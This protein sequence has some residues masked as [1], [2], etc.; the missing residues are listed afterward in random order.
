[1]DVNLITNSLKTSHIDYIVL[2]RKLL[3]FVE[4]N[5]DINDSSKL[6]QGRIVEQMKGYDYG[7]EVELIFEVDNGMRIRNPMSGNELASSFV[8]MKP[9]FQYKQSKDDQFLQTNV[10]R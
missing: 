8:T 1:M 6:V 2:L 5:K 7:K 9:C 10:I 4:Q 3:Q